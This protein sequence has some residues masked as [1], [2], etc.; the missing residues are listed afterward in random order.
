[1]PIGGGGSRVGGG[2]MGYCEHCGCHD[3]WSGKATYVRH[4]GAIPFSFL[5]LR[6]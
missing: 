4:F 6:G 3:G 5:C 2:E 1:M